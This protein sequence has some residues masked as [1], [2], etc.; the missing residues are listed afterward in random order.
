MF[1]TAKITSPQWPVFSVT[2]ESRSRMA[3]KSD[4]YGALMINRSNRIL[5]PFKLLQ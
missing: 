3:M 2:D 1:P 5:I 4:P